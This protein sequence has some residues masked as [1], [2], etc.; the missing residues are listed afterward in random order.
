[1]LEISKIALY[2]FWR[3]YV[4]PKY[5]KKAKLYYMDTDSF[6]VSFKTED[7]YKNIEKDVEKK[8]ETSNIILEWEPPKVESKRVIGLLKDKLCEKNMKESAGL[9][10]KTYSYLTDDNN[11]IKKTKV[12]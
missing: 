9:R 10:G 5:N 7:V 3:Y 12:V 2:E 4:K 8:F 6:T 1:M 11:E